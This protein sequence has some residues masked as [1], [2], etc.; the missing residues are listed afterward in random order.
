MAL[1]NVKYNK[2]LYEGS[3]GVLWCRKNHFMK[4]RGWTNDNSPWKLD[5]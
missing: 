1:K 2:W 3:D 5:S 4:L